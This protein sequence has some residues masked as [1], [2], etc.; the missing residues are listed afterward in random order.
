ML[1]RSPPP[2]HFPRQSLQVFDSLREVGSWKW[3]E[4]GIGSRHLSRISRW[5]GKREAWGQ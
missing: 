5:N 3:L 4:V 1:T 2:D